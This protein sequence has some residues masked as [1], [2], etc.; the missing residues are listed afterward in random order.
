MKNWALLTLLATVVSFSANA[1][2]SDV[3]KPSNIQERV[4]EEVAD[5]DISFRLELFDVDL[6]E[7]LGISS[8]YRYEVEPSYIANYFTRVD[9]WEVKTDIRAGDI[10]KDSL[11]TPIY[12]NIDRDQSIYFVRQFKSKWEA[13]KA[14]P[15]LLNRLP[16][17][18]K[19][20]LDY[21]APGDFVSI[22]SDM[23]IAFG[24]SAG[25]L[26]HIDGLD[27]DANLYYVLKGKF[28]IHVFRM[29]DNKVRVKLIAQKSNG[30][31]GDAS[32]GADIEFFG[33]SILDKQIKKIFELDALEIGMG[34]GKG[35][36]FLIDYIFDLNDEKAKEAYNSILSSTYKFKDL[37]IF[38]EFANE[39][40]L[41]IRLLSSYEKADQ[42]SKED[43]DLKEK[44]VERVFKGTNNYD[45]DNSKLKLGMLLASFDRDVSYTENLVSYDANDGEK[46]FFFYPIH[47]K[48]KSQQIGISPF[49]Y[50]E[51]TKLS[52]F[53]LVPMKNKEDMGSNFSD[54]GV[55]YDIKDKYF[56]QSEQVKLKQLVRD[57]IPASIYDD[58]DWAEFDETTAHKSAR[59]FFQVIFKAEAF[60]GLQ[61][62]SYDDLHSKLVEFYKNRKR[63]VA[64]PVHG[65]WRR[66]WR[67]ITILGITERMSIKKVA[68]ALHSAMTDVD[69]GA[70]ERVRK[71]LSIRENDLF[72][73]VGIGF[74]ISLLPQDSLEN[75]IFIT[76]NLHARETENVTLK[77]GDQKF[78]KIY[79]ELRFAHGA[80][81][82]RSWDLRVANE[83]DLSMEEEALLLK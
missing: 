63:L 60:E 44:R 4:K 76:L 14:L 56:R 13:T 21:L 69:L 18:A 20:A 78:S 30:I 10:I 27:A 81:N 25:F 48:S 26:D 72:E 38:Q 77:Y 62:I 61:N 73:K 52:Y 45:Y 24:A 40:E 35:S 8:R 28:L 41:E 66:I 49:K 12:L 74:L 15:Y 55:T 39:R 19:R 37:A 47:T 32:I 34:K 67:T 11:D 50:K 5:L 65:V 71:L 82:D 53:G 58:I 79:E 43:V 1:G 80:I 59:G 46:H 2:L 22:P 33:V 57:N 17:N 9:R 70:K 54:Y 31:G 7:G 29:K 51:K 42:L 6:F 16:I 83:Q 3:L 23:T 75:K 64:G 68:K 36:Q